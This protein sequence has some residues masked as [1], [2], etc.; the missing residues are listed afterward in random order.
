MKMKCYFL[1]GT[2]MKVHAKLDPEKNLCI[3][4]LK[5]IHSSTELLERPY[6]GKC[7]DSFYETVVFGNNRHRI[8]RVNSTIY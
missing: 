8:L 6:T 4:E 7:A 2:C 5:Q 3:I 1:P